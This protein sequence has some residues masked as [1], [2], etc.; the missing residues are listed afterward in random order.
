MSVLKAVSIIVLLILSVS[1][2][3][4]E[5]ENTHI[6]AN[7]ATGRYLYPAIAGML[8]V[9]MTVI[10]QMYFVK[11]NHTNELKR[12]SKAERDGRL[13]ILVNEICEITGDAIFEKVTNRPEKSWLNLHRIQSELSVLDIEKFEGANEIIELLK[14]RI[15]QGGNV[16]KADKTILRNKLQKLMKKIYASIEL[17]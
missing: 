1:S 13:R 17:K 12:L 4:A 15:E 7:T 2:V 8:G 10:A 9:L 14:N 11:K 16:T 3:Y 5:V 6:V